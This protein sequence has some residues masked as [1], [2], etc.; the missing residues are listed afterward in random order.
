MVSDLERSKSFYQDMLGAE[1]YR[2]NGGTSV[3]LRFPGTWL[4]MVTGGVPTADKPDVR[5]VAP[6]DPRS[7]SHEMTIKVPDCRAYEVLRSCGVA[8][9][10][11]PV[12]YV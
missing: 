11:P 8:F 6:T 10:T 12:E 1:L 7:G 4:L 9:L 5:F 2:E 3:V